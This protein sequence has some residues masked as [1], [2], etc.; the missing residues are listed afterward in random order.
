MR[1]IHPDTNNTGD[2]F[3]EIKEK[4]RDV[5]DTFCRDVEDLELVPDHGKFTREK[6]DWKRVVEMDIC[7]VKGK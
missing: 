7:F 1:K 6:R 3:A 4:L 2:N 5:M